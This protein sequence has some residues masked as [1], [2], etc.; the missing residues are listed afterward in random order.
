ME[1]IF[2]EEMQGS[3]TQLVDFSKKVKCTAWHPKKDGV[4]A[5]SNLNALY[6]YST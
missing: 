5:V 4:V 6:L 2:P 1:P 3:A